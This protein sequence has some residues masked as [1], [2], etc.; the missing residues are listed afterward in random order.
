M[1]FFITLRKNKSVFIII[2]MNYDFKKLEQR[3]KKYIADKKV[4]GLSIVI[5]KNDKILYD[6]TYGDAKE[7][8]LY[9]LASLTKPITAVAILICQDLGLLNIDDYIDKYIP[10]LTN[11][12]VKDKEGVYRITI[13]QL[14]CHSSGFPTDFTDHRFENGNDTLEK[15]TSTFKD[16]VLQSIPGTKET[17]SNEAYDVAARIVEVVTHLKYEEFLKRYI[18]DPLD[19]HDTMYYLKESDKDNIAVLY[20]DKNGELIPESTF[21][22]GFD[23]YPNGYNGG[24]AGLISTVHD[25]L[26]FA[27]ML[28]NQGKGILSKNAFEQMIKRFDTPYYLSVFG[29]GVYIRGHENYE[30]IPEG[31]YGWSGAYGG[32]Y[33]S[34]P[35][36]KITVVYLHNSLSYGGSGAI[37]TYDLE[38]DIC[39][40]FHLEK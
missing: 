25:Y 26:K 8:T 22:Y 24:G 18:F 6:K 23:K 19:M 29:L 3:L 12:R 17:Y 14:L 13:R 39:E 1:L 32:H 7:N 27:L 34:I 36:D 10:F 15:V 30:H 2:N 4:S 31:S 11:F 38:D 35:K 9:R 33:F 28:T 5:A 16:F 20:T 40:I 21:T 37:H